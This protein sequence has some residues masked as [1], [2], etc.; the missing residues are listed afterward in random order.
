ME[1]L[2][3]WFKSEAGIIVSLVFFFPLGLFLL[4]RYGQARKSEKA[5][6]SLGIALLLVF[7]VSMS[8]ANASMDKNNQELTGKLSV[9]TKDFEKLQAENNDLKQTETTYIAYKEKMEPYEELSEADA[10]KRQ[11]DAAAAKKVEEQL[12]GLPAI[13][14]VTSSDKDKVAKVKTLYNALTEDQKKLVD[15]TA[16]PE[17][18][19]KIQELEAKEKKEQEEKKKKEEAEAKKKAEE[20]ARKAEEARLKAEE[21]ARGYETGITYDQLARTP[22]E[23]LAKK[24]KFYGKVLQVMDGVSSTQ[25]RLAV[26]D[27]Y[28]TVIYC[29]YDNSIVGSRILEDDYITVKGVSE[30]LMSY[31]STMGGTITIPSVL[32]EQIDQ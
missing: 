6:A 10:K 20:E 29:D 24:V 22:D 9:L 26:N 31:K 7:F 27:D 17:L 14:A 8:N 1:K 16:V 12:T 28:D 15:Y 21:E 11:T 30:G 23:Y 3:N 2:Q 5:L 25:I 19:S 13:T 18:E 32:V 4:W